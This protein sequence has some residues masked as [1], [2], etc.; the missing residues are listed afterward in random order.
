MIKKYTADSYL[1][2]FLQAQ[3]ELGEDILVVHSRT[4]TKKSW[5]GFYSKEMVEI[6]AAP[7]K[8]P[9]EKTPPK[10]VPSRPVLTEEVSNRPEFTRL[11]RSTDF[12]VADSSHSVKAAPPVQQPRMLKPVLSSSAPSPRPPKTPPNSYKASSCPSAYRTVRITESMRTVDEGDGPRSQKIVDDPDESEKLRKLLGKLLEDKRQLLPED[13][14]AKH[15]SSMAKSR[16][17]GIRAQS[18]R[19]FRD[20]EDEDNREDMSRSSSELSYSP[21]SV[22]RG[23]MA[24]SDNVIAASE[25]ITSQ[26]IENKISELFEMLR[27]I[28]STATKVLSVPSASCPEGLVKLRNR[29]QAIEMPQEIQ[30]EIIDAMRDQIP[31]S[32]VKDPSVFFPVARKWLGKRLKFSSEPVLKS[33]NGPRIIALIGPTGVGKTTTIAKLA[34]SFALNVADKKTVSLFSMDT[35]RIGAT[36]QLAQYAQIID[37]EIEIIFDPDEVPEIYEKHKNKDIILI[38]TAGRCQKDRQE[39]AK[40]KEFLACFSGVEKYLV[41]SA[42]TKFSDMLESVTRFGEVGFDHLVFTKV[43]ET[44]SVGP[45]MALLIKSERP[46]AYITHG[47]GVPDDFR[48]AEPEYFLSALFPDA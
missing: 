22:R 31:S 44:N 13:V 25:G 11:S 20:V 48:L 34:A 30:D 46:L 38:D 7:S 35:F 1:E 24:V 10:N 27:Q 18:D 41:L 45:L 16:S 40:M 47:K 28:Q 3:N 2:A 19:T 21:Q 37:A 14:P 4:F 15:A 26:V 6:T 17:M 33:C 5:A 42:T 32:T 23:P 36:Q 43:D 12:A 9:V 39:L 29:L 8:S